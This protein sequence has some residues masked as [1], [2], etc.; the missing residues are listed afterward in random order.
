MDITIIKNILLANKERVTVAGTGRLFFGRSQVDLPQINIDYY[1]GLVIILVYERIEMQELEDLMRLIT[2]VFPN[3]LSIYYQNRLKR[4]PDW[5]HLYGDKLVE[6]LCSEFGNKFVVKLR[7]NRNPGLFVD[8][9]P[10]RQRIQLLS[11]SKICLNLFSYTGSYTV[12]MIAGSAKRVDSYDMNPNFHNWC[13]QNLLANGLGTKQ[14]YFKKANIL[15]SLGFIQKRGPYDLIVI[16]PPT[17]QGSSFN[18]KKDYIKIIRR[19][20]NWLSDNGIVFFV[21]NAT[22]ISSESF[23]E[24]IEANTNLLY[25]ESDEL[26]F[27]SKADRDLKILEYRVSDNLAE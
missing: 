7:E 13:R 3:I 23:K 2:D 19:V 5:T 18:W 20:P 1:S 25:F 6:H 11:N 8:S 24:I 15:K 27:A 10:L 16:D 4:H 12:V 21:L 17:M 9:S 14:T 22:N 26:L